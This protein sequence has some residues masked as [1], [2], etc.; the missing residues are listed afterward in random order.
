MFSEG[1]NQSL[2]KNINEPKFQA[3]IMAQKGK[4]PERWRVHASGFILNKEKDSV[5]LLYRPKHDWY[6]SPGGTAKETECKDLLNPKVEELEGIL[7]REQG[8]EIKGL[9]TGKPQY[10]GALVRPTPDGYG[11]LF[12]KFV[13]PTISGNAEI[14]EPENF[15][16]CRYFKIADLRRVKKLAPDVKYFVSML[17]EMY[18]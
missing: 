7:T 9:K 17:Q 18:G 2:I 11:I 14:N 13:M 16:H 3:C 15:S 1:N 8:E 10:V 4:K 12:G 5:L 6:E